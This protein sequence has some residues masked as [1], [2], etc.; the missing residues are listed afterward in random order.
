MCARTSARGPST[1]RT[2]G[3]LLLAALGCAEPSGAQR[4]VVRGAPARESVGASI[5]GRVD[6]APRDGATEEPRRSTPIAREIASI[7]ADAPALRGAVVGTYV[8]DRK[9]EPIVALSSELRLVP[10]STQ[11]ILTAAAAL[12]LLGP[13]HRFRT[14]VRATATPEHGVLSADL[15]VVG[16]AD[17][18]IGPRMHGDDPWRVF[19][20]WAESLRRSG[21]SKI[22]GSI[23]GDAHRLESPVRGS[24]WEAGDLVRPF[25]APLDALVFHEA[26]WFVDATAPQRSGSPTLTVGPLGSLVTVRSEIAATPQAPSALT[27]ARDADGSSW[28]ARGSMPSGSK[29]RLD[30]AHDEPAPYFVAALREGLSRAGLDVREAEVRVTRTPRADASVPLFVH[31]SP[32][33]RELLGPM[34][35]ESVNLYAEALL[36]AMSE[37]A[38]R[39]SVAGGL[40]RARRALGELGLESDSAELVD[41]SGLSRRNM[42]T[43]SGLVAVLRTAI[44]APGG[45]AL[46]D[47]L[48]VAGRSGTLRTRMKGGSLEGRVRAKT[49]TMRGVRALAGELETRE[50]ERLYF[51][52]L[53]NQAVASPSAID[54]VLEAALARL[55]EWRR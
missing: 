48:P 1:R 24:S 28:V 39:A 37:D 8:C 17:P 54:S 13:E 6:S 43:P 5:P 26:S 16:S 18:T 47:A 14:E 38:T 51:A 35:G 27:L 21:I 45:D 41:G 31:E 34:L 32:P 25:A 55:V 4:L 2:W 3:V 11:K 9:G 22:R 42:V 40:T 44:V 46:R 30:A 7:L 10:A 23:V 12:R 50:G 52:F 36:V 29:V 49:G 53:V 15:V 19:S 20:Q 33:V